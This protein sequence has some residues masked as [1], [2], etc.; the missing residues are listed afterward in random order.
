MEAVSAKT[1]M[2]KIRN[3]EK[4][5][6]AIH[7]INIGAK[8]GIFEKLNHAKEKGLTVSELAQKLDLH[9]PYLKL[10]CQTAHHFRI[11]DCDNHGNFKFQPFLDEILGDP[12]HFRNY[13]PN[14]AVDVE[15]VGRGMVAAAENFK[16]GKT[17]EAFSDPAVAKLAYGTTRNIY[18]AFLFLVFP[19]NEH[20]KQQLEQGISY[21]DIGCGNGTLIIQ[22]AQTFPKSRFVGIGPDPYGIEAAGAAIGQLNLQGRVSVEHIG[23]E[24]ITYAD[25]FDMVSMVV[26]LH[27]IKPEVRDVVVRNA[28]R[29]LKKG[30]SILILDFPYPNHLADFR[31]PIY[32]YG[33]M[34]QFYETFMGSVHLTSAEQTQLLVQAGFKSIQRIPVGKGMFDFI[35]AAK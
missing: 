10:W 19:N 34:D 12:N 14:I 23:G 15:L 5:F 30:G 11:L 18:L 24:E 7:L 6:M 28:Y 25:E 8:V 17:V 29:A 1:Q 2:E 3:F 4:G 13:L 32:D 33:I 20:L 9:E 27:E 26:T 21:L 35:T 22:F 31:N 16:S